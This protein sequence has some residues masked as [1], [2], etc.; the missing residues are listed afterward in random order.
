MDN[1]VDLLFTNVGSVYL[2]HY[3]RETLEHD[4]AYVQELEET[5]TLFD[6]DLEAGIPKSGGCTLLEPEVMILG[7]HQLR[8]SKLEIVFKEYK[9]GCCLIISLAEIL[10]WYWRLPLTKL[11]LLSIFTVTDVVA[12]ACLLGALAIMSFFK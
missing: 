10:L 2:M 1:T 5:D 8:S 7:D 9:L 12:T 3:D 6:F 11:S 4:I